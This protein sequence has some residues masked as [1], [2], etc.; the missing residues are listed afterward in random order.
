L[1]GFERLRLLGVRKNTGSV[2]A[3][4]DCL[5]EESPP[6]VSVVIPCLNEED[7]LAAC[8]SKARKALDDAGIS[9]EILVADNGST[10]ASRAIALQMG[11]RVID[12]PEPPSRQPRGYGHGLMTGIGAARGKFILMGDADDSYDFLDLARFIEV[13]DQ[14]YDLV[15]GCRFPAGGGKIMP[16]AMPA[17]HRWWGNPMFSWLAQKW[18]AVPVR[19][20]HCGMRAFRRDLFDSL[21]L[22]CTGMEFAAEMII[23]ASLLHARIAE[24]PITLHPDGRT[25]RKPH[26]KTFRDG[27]RT[28]RLFL[29][30]SPTW[31]FNLPGLVLILLGL[32]GYCIAMPGLTIW[33]VGFDAHTLLFSTLAILC[34]YQSVVF[35]LISK[36]F[37]IAIGLLPDD[38]RISRFLELVNVEKGLVAA[39]VVLLAGLGLLLTVVVGWGE[40]GFG[41]LDY[42]HSMRLVIPGAMLT[43][44]GVQTILSSFFL[45]IIGMARRTAR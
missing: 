32:A 29:V 35:G 28:L 39:S 30:F 3:F 2:E 23:K 33:K 21:D 4:S 22:R 13:L 42:A 41:N 17:L 43:A 6:D 26:L 36:A 14:G 8:V 31:M 20:I 40:T 38:K 9:G 44:L 10:D 37:C 5:S 34:G 11:A 7:T 45:A 16:G 15:Q 19:D 1:G 25:K 18:F 24:I 12:V 27:W